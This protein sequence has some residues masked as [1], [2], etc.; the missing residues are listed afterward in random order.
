[1]SRNNWRPVFP[2]TESGKPVDLLDNS[3]WST[4]CTIQNFRL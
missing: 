2:V 1:V 3:V 4:T